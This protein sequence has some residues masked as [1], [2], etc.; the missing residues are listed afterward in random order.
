MLFIELYI[1]IFMSDN[2]CSHLKKM[3]YT[4]KEKIIL[5]HF[6]I[7]QLLARGGL[8]WLWV[9]HTTLQMGSID[10]GMLNPA[11]H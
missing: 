8:V 10:S 5:F 3:T 4:Y 1:I 2:L 9:L 7:T 11:L 6:K